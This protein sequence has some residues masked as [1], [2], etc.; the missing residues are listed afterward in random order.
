MDVGFEQE[1]R[2]ALFHLYDPDYA[3]SVDICELL[4]CEGRER[5]LAVQ[6][7]VIRAITDLKPASEAPPGA[8]ARQV[9]ELLHARF[10][11]HTTLEQ[12]AEQLHL[13]YSST[14]RLQRTAVHEL[15]RLL[16]ERSRG[17]PRAAG[18]R[19]DTSA[20]AIDDLSHP[21]LPDWTR[22]AQQEVASLSARAPGARSDVLQVIESV[23]GLEHAL[24]SRRPIHVEVAF[25]QPNLVAALH[26]SVLRQI[27]IT[28]LGRLARFSLDGRVLVFARQEE[29]HVKI[30]LT[31]AN[32]PQARPTEQ[33]LVTDVLPLEGVSYKAHLEGD[34]AFLWVRLPAVGGLTVLVVDDNPDMVTFYRRATEGT[35]YHIIQAPDG[36]S[37]ADAARELA[38]DVIVLDVMLPDADGW[39]LLMK[40]RKDAA[41]CDT[42]VVVCT[43]IR[44]RELAL[45]LGATAFISKPVSADQFIQALEGAC[46]GAPPGAARASVSN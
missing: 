26:P 40:L 18:D 33:D 1:I 31:T 28:A 44:E 22:Q 7:A 11:L 10:V 12:T 24:V 5:T 16:W 38:P 27:L 34:H 25:A 14:W 8:F 13:S 42:P 4:G 32:D 35:S 23:I 36:Q 2:E 43:V 17:L 9:Y 6:T 37:L 19:Q 45:S 46:A 39:Q 3:P 20:P 15:T 29:G 30:A 41:T 21:E